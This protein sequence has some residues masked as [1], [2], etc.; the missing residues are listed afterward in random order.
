[1]SGAALSNF[2]N[3]SDDAP[4]NSG[5]GEGS[6][7]AKSKPEAIADQID[8]GGLKVQQNPKTG[9]QEG[10]ITIT[11][12]SQPGTRVTVRVETYLLKPG[13]PPIRHANVEVVKPGPKHRPE[14]VV[15]KHIDQ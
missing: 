13:G 7:P 4:G 1:M 6:Q 11:N 15:N 10:N 12:P 3:A 8:K 5:S 14:V 9:A 2:M